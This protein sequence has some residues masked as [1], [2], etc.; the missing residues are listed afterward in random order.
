MMYYIKR[1]F[2]M[3]IQFSV[4]VLAIILTVCASITPTE[5]GE[6][7]TSTKPPDLTCNAYNENLCAAPAVQPVSKFP[8]STCNLYQGDTCI[9]PIISRPPDSGCSLYNGDICVA[10]IVH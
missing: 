4:F 9:A 8:D 7:H 10:P 2:E 3:I 1:G 5:K 6:T